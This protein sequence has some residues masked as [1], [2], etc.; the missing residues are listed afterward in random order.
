MSK[1][2]GMIL[3]AFI[4]DAIALG[5]H[6]IYSLDDIQEKFGMINGL[7]A[8]ATN[9][10]DTKVKG[11]FTHYGD[12]ALMVL[13]YLKLSVVI[14]KEPFYAYYMNYMKDYQGYK[15]H[16]TKETVENL[17][18]NIREGSHSAELGGFTRFP[19]VIYFNSND[20]NKIC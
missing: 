13:Q 10:H 14:E 16:A 2:R 3:G 5:P 19:A 8:P 9:Y 7:T 6:W 1:L 12:Q 20:S 15:D 18:R 11:D 4:G 17:G